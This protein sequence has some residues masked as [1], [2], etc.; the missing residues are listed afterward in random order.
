[1]ESKVFHCGVPPA[2][3]GEVLRQSVAIGRPVVISLLHYK[4]E[5]LLAED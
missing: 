1:L 2:F 4:N 5:H 3:T